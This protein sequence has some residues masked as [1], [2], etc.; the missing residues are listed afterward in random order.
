[1]NTDVLQ[2]D[3]GTA[4]G[5]GRWV[6]AALRQVLI[7][8]LQGLQWGTIDLREPGR[9]DQ[10]LG[11]G[12]SGEPLV[13]LEVR[14]P[15]AWAYVALGGD[16]GAGQSYAL[17]QWEASNL[18]DLLRIFLRNADVLDGIDSGWSTLAMPLY[19]RIHRRRDNTRKGSRKNIA[20]HYDLGNDFFE[21]FLDEQLLYSS[22]VYPTEDATL[23]AAQVDKMERICRGLDL[24][25]GQQL[26]EIGSGW[27]GFALHAA[28]Q[29]GVQVHTIT[30]SEEQCHH[31][32]GRIEQAGL[33]DQ[34][35]VELVDYRD[36]PGTACY[37]HVVSIEMIEAVGHRHMAT[38]MATID[39]V[40]RPGGRAMIQGIT[41]PDRNFD[42]YLQTSDFIRHFI[43]PG[44]SLISLQQ[45][46]NAAAGDTRL[47]LFH[48]EEIGSHYARTLREWHQRF[49]AARGDLPEKY[50]EAEFQRLWSFYLQS[51]EACFMERRTGAV[52]MGF[53]KAEVV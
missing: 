45:V 19:R 26:L 41:L 24:Q 51:C 48:L 12:E 15:A 42:R 18:R 35:R 39:R 22:A 46:L 36:V 50:Q 43:F 20:A 28:Q 6:G 32:Q 33:Q 31:T 23:E 21:S 8:R 27:G 1:M 29:Y 52:Q 40:L 38:Y 17:G 11:S 30:L 37:D 7:R 5:P 10:V 14:D 53:I 3:A 4:P 49:L 25:P 16:I 13:V 2:V 34:V 9:E 44:G 47:E